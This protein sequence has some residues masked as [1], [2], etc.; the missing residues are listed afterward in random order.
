MGRVP[1]R[2]RV[3]AASFPG[4]TARRKAVPEAQEAQAERE[5]VVQQAALAEMEKATAELRGRVGKSVELL[6]Q[7]AER[8]SAEARSDDLEGGFLVARRIIAADLE[9][10]T[11]HLMNLVRSA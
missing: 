4:S 8:L 9:A 10:N 5:R 2:P 7:V 1:N 11:E 3:E 6:N